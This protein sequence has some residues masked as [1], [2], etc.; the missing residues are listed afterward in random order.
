MNERDPRPRDGRNVGTDDGDEEACST[1]IVSY[2][3]SGVTTLPFPNCPLRAGLREPP[4]VNVMLLT[5]MEPLSFGNFAFVAS[6]TLGFHYLFCHRKRCDKNWLALTS[7][8]QFSFLLQLLHISIP[9][10]PMHDV[11]DMRSD[12]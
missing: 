12:E 3:S 2:I 5:V 7:N 10:R 4:S 1:E 8:A 9:R 6:I 11:I